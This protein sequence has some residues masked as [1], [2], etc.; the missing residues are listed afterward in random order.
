MPARLVLWAAAPLGLAVFAIVRWTG[1]TSETPLVEVWELLV[2]AS[3]VLW[4]ALASVGLRMLETLPRR[5]VGGFLVAV[6]GAFALLLVLT[7]LAKIGNDVVVAGQRWKNGLL[8][9]LAAVAILPWLV[10]LE[11][12]RSRRATRTRPSSGYASCAPA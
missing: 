4:T 2:A 5:N 6:Y 12:M 11:Q 8:H 10:A 1:T 7:G 3:V 9:A